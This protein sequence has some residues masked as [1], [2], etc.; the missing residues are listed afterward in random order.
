MVKY[1]LGPDV[2]LSLKQARQTSLP[3]P[4]PTVHFRHLS[5]VAVALSFDKVDDDLEA[6]E[7][8]MKMDEA[9]FANHFGSLAGLA[10]M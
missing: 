5:H 8:R 1:E 10:L 7:W 3:I 2:T 6:G 9:G 4:C